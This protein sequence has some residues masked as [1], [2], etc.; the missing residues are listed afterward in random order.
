[1]TQNKTYQQTLDF[2]YEK[3]PMFSRIGKAALKPDLTNTIKLCAALGNPQQK[4]KSVHIA[5]TNGKGSTSHALAAVLQQARYKT[6]LYTSPHLTDFRERIK[7]NGEMIAKEWVVRFVEDHKNLVEEIQPSFFEI[8]VAMAFLAFAEQEVDIAIIE[9]GLGGRLDSTNIITP[10]L[11]VI[12]NIS[13]DHTDLL[14]NTLAEI[15]AEKAGII[16]QNVPVVIGEQQDETERVF[17]EHSVHRQAPLYYAQSLWGMV[18]VKEDARYQ[19]YK[20]VNN[21]KREMYD[22]KT[23]LQGNYQ[24]HNIKTVLTAAEL[25][26][27]AGFKITRAATIAALSNVKST[28]GLQGRWQWLSEDP[29]IICDVAHNA[30]GIQEVLA[31]WQKLP[32][33]SKHIVIGFVKDKDVAGTLAYFPKDVFYYFCNAQIQ[34]AMPAAELQAIAQQAGL[35]GEA[36]NSVAEAVNAARHHMSKADALL[37]T[38]SFFIVGEALEL[39]NNIVA[40]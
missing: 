23:D 36:Y 32:A 31:Q 19:Y 2:L 18:R 21:A 7:V 35:N 6:G 24:Q 12:T 25:L 40:V 10:I 22:L 9:T 4:F 37:I 20:A 39:M 30:A 5:G 29:A 1:M 13:Y 26:S 14:G 16:K 17:F 33:A 11:S 3:L 28:T 27:Y 38:G 8:T 15:A 34:R